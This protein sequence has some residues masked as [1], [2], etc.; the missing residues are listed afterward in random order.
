MIVLLLFKPG[1]L[2]DGLNALL[3]TIPDVQLVVHAHDVRAVLE[4]CQKNPNTLIIMVIKSGD[5]ALIGSIPEIKLLN[6]QM[7]M[8]ALLQNEDDREVAEKAGIDLILSIGTPVQE[9]KSKIEYMVRNSPTI[10][11][12]EKKRWLG[13]IVTDWEKERRELNLKE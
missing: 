8:I 1:P 3:S 4:F 13:E 5:R 11:T 9:L 6:P 12:F 10:E 7:P 2:R